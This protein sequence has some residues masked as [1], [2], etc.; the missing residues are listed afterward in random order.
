MSVK[1][2]SLKSENE[3]VTANEKNVVIKETLAK[4]CVDIAAWDT[5]AFKEEMAS[6]YKED[7]QE[8]RRILHKLKAFQIKGE[9]EKAIKVF[10]KLKTFSKNTTLPALSTESIT[11]KEKSSIQS[12]TNSTK[13]TLKT[14]KYGELVTFDEETGISVLIIESEGAALLAKYLPEKMAYFSKCK[15]WHE[16]TGTHWQPLT[17]SDRIDCVLIEMIYVGSGSVGFKNCYKNNCKSL[18]AEGNFLPLPESNK[19]Y[20]PFQNGLF[21]YKTRELIPITPKNAQTWVLPYNY[22]PELTAPHTLD[23]LKRAVDGDCDTVAFLRA[24]L[25]ALLYGRAD[26]QKFLHL[27]GVGGTGKGTFMRLAT[28]LV[29]KHNAVSTSLQVME[30]NQFETARFFEKRLVMITD[31]DKYGGSINCLKSLTGQDPLRIERKHQQQDG[32]FIYS[33]LVVMASNE[34]LTTTD[35]SSGLERRRL[36]V[37]FDKQVTDKEKEYWDQYGGIENVLHSEIAG[38]VNWL[39]EL[40]Q[41]QISEAIRKPPQKTLTA[42]IEAMKASNAIAEWTTENIIKDATAWTQIG[43]KREIKAQ[44]VET[45]FEHSD[46]K[47]YPNYL[48]WSQRHNRQPHSVRRFR[49]VLA[50]TLL[51][52]KMEFIETRRASGMGLSGI[53]LKKEWENSIL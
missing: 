50:D 21:N 19:D 36:T 47:L 34:N 3:G 6:L 37:E 1:N 18:I 9:V 52:L 16:F 53:R 7:R 45:E 5:N 41:D 12:S 2:D 27:K 39:L 44:G 10:L 17:Y 28:E 8:Y 24:W 15:T 25:A 22:S 20:L 42:N 30:R 4:L 13:P 46:E 14:I 51:T 33:G 38:L 35:H 11:C 23:W 43:D 29:G 48:K 49:E 31:S 40:S 32:D 26:L